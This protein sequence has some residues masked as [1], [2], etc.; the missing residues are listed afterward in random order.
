MVL[1]NGAKG[2]SSFATEQSDGA[3]MQLAL[4]VI[5]FTTQIQQP[6][7]ARV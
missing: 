5:V 7:Y 6:I 3:K 4:T 1:A 2:Y